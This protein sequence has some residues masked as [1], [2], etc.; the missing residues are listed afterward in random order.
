[1]SRSSPRI[2]RPDR[3]G[4]YRHI[5][6]RNGKVIPAAYALQNQLEY[7]AE[8]SAI[9]FVGGNYFPFDRAGLADYDATGEQLVRQLWGD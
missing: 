3:R 7:F 5:R 8:V 1:M 6:D 4:L 2:A 9:H